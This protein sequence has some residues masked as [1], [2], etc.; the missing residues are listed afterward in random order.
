[1]ASLA[2]RGFTHLGL[3]VSKDSIAVAVL[4]PYR[5]HADVDKIFH[6]EQS[7][8]RL[9]ARFRD[10]ARLWA[11]YEAGPTGYELYR[12]LV[13]LG[14][15]CEVVA[16]SLVPKGKGDKVNT[17]KRDARRL[18]GLHRAGELTPIAVPTP[19]Q[20]GVRD[21]CRIRGQM[22]SDLT[23]ARNRLS[24]FLLRHGVVWRGGSNWTSRHERWLASLHFEQPAVAAGF[25]H[26]RAAV[27]LRDASLE[28]IEGDLG[29][30]CE[31]APSASRSG[32]W[33]PSEASRRSAVSAWPPR[34]S[35]GG[36]FPTP[37][38]S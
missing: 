10:P 14:V 23:R 30:W 7:V 17:D 2:H 29:P 1:M 34:C 24:G 8:R 28:A 18:A 22:V 12:L 13:S 6:D 37:A 36:A 9:V 16:P 11:C 27:Q 20:E 31:R 38:S 3:D 35:T 19:E 26:Y 33:P 21:L 4:T 5:D 32:A 15:R 25:R